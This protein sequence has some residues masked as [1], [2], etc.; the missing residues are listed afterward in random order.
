MVVSLI[1]AAGVI[2]LII[3]LAVRGLNRSDGRTMDSFEQTSPDLSP[4]APMADLESELL[5]TDRQRRPEFEYTPLPESAGPY[6]GED[7][8]A[9]LAGTIQEKLKT[10]TP[11]TSAA[12]KILK[13][14]DNPNVK[15]EEIASVVS[16]DPVF[17][18]N[19]L[20][21]VNSAYYSLPNKVS[22]VGSAILFMG[23]NT[24][25]VM[26]M[27]HNLKDALPKTQNAQQKKEYNDL[28]LHST[29]VSACAYYLGKKI[30]HQYEQELGTI[31]LLHDIGKY[32][33]PLFEKK[34]G[35]PDHGSSCVAEALSYGVDH[36]VLG[37]YMAREW[38]LP[39]MIANAV[40]Y[41][42]YPQF[43]TPERIPNEYRQISFI[44]CLADLVCKAYG[45]Y[46][47]GEQIYPILED[48]FEL[49]ELDPG[50]NGI[51]SKELE[52]ELE[53]A[54]YAVEVFMNA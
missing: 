25:K 11:P 43:F 4:S 35:V 1:V 46:G 19:V 22:S 15:N 2:V 40:H 7:L 23:Y 36:G 49:Y 52:K 8:S 32:Y 37:G 13:L 30:F 27:Q 51:F 9:E 18:A 12:F 48:Y 45:Y 17:S 41:H 10:L 50:L 38:N 20:K 5:P 34:A 33:L 53:K 16:T 39:E 3:V 28:W 54:R 31:G 14:L 24:F 42:H 47:K 44:T 29:V 26:V 21:V 6:E